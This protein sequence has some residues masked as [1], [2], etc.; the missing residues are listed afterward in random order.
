MQKN[1]M[2]L[3]FN[4][5]SFLQCCVDGEYFPADGLQLDFETAAGV[6]QAYKLFNQ[7]N[8][9]LSGDENITA[10]AWAGGQCLLPVVLGNHLPSL[11]YRNPRRR[12][13]LTAKIRFKAPLAEALNIYTFGISSASL[14]ITKDRGVVLP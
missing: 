4:E 6:R 1:W 13:L 2:D 5:I 9:L 7:I 14:W 3:Q 11:H 8:R 12:G 10:N